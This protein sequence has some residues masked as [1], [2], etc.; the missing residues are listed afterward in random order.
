MLFPSI[1]SL[2]YTPV[3]T[4]TYLFLRS[5]YF[6]INFHSKYIIPKNISYEIYTSNLDVRP[7]YTLRYLFLL[8]W[9]KYDKFQ[10]VSL[11]LHI[12]YMFSLSM[13]VFRLVT[14]CRLV[15]RHRQFGK[16]YFS[17]LNPDGFAVRYQ[18]FSETVC[19]PRSQHDFT[20]QKT[21][22]YILTSMIN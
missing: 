3:G 17:I 1:I 15:G 5:T 4:L 16:I 12:K 13:W 20:T 18:Y 7:T 19:L 8:R 2:Y 11:D 9:A 10:K 6:P 14:P 22:I 21:N